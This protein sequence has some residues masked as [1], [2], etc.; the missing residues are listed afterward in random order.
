MAITSYSELKTA[1]ADWANRT[2]LTD[3]IPDF[4]TLAE[5]R[6]NRLLTMAK[7]EIDAS[8]TMTPD[9]RYVAYPTDMGQP[10]ALWLET[11]LPRWEIIYKT[12]TELSV[13]SNVS[14]PPNYYTVD[15]SNLA[16]DY[17][18]DQAHS[19]TFRYVK[20]LTLSDSA[21]TNAIL[22]E[23]PDLYLYAG[24][25]EVGK[26]IRDIEM[27]Q[28]YDALFSRALQ[29]ANDAESRVYS[30]SKL[31]TDLPVGGNTFN[32]TRGY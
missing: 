11:F 25:V 7:M 21:T 9:S 6:L 12:P 20:K 13:T 4:I 16:F 17:K 5:S 15:G 23:Y 26:Y 30:N 1:I 3:K 10:I 19:L 24:L 2:D 18:A 14:A 8:L 27:I 31:S 28:T 22:E 32:I 29:E